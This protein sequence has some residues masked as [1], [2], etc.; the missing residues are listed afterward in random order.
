M[1]KIFSSWIG[2]SVA[3]VVFLLCTYWIYKN[4]KLEDLT[5][6]IEIE[7]VGNKSSE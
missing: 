3:V 1:K 2:F 6:S 5:G 7:K 4:V